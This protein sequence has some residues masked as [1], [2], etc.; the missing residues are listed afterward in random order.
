[1]SDFQLFADEFTEADQGDLVGFSCGE[2][3]PGR[4]CTQWITGSDVHESIKRGTKV[5]LYRDCGNRVVGFGSVGPVKWRWPLP[6]GSYTKLLYI[7]MLGLDYRFHGQPKDK[8]WRYSHQIMRHLIFSA[9]E[10]NRDLA[11]PA[12]WLLLLVAPENVQAIRLYKEF[13]FQLVPN[14]MRGHGLSVMKHR[15]AAN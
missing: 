13:D 3:V 5:W 10:M 7:P 11:I 15:L 1:L 14:V 2:T 8:A 12:D 9:H 4:Y 6:D